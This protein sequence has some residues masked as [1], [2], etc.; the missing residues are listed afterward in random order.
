[1]NFLSHYY[2]DRNT[3]DPNQVLGS[4]LPDLVKNANKLWN[5]HP[6]KKKEEF[7]DSTHL[8]SILSGWR[9]HVFVDNYFHNSDFFKEH[10]RKI[11]TAIAPILEDSP[12]RSFFMAHIALEVMLDSLLLTRELVNPNDFYGHLNQSH[13]P[14]ITRFL[15]INQLEDTPRFLHFFDKFIEVNYL[16]SYR[17]TRN[18]MF[19]LNRVC[20]RIW[21]NPLNNTQKL[22]LTEVLIDYLKYLE[23]SFMSIFEDIDRRL[24]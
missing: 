2:F 21:E 3:S 9:R 4:V 15:E 5:L 18:V 16:N 13:R 24:N 6:E 23:L 7:S 11:R 1:M 8:T 22:Q 17:E 12:V 20:M 19:A 14:S 10:T